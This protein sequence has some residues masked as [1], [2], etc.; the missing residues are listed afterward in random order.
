MATFVKRHLRRGQ[1]ITTFGPGSIVDLRDESVMMGGLDFW[2]KNS[3]H[4]I[5]EPNLER[6]LGVDAF[7]IA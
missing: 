7:R 3:V 2:P 4:E 1:T 6:V 5:H